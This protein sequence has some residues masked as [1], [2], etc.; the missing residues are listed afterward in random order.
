[1]DKKMAAKV[2]NKNLSFI[3]VTIFA[4]L[5]CIMALDRAIIPLKNGGMLN[6]VEYTLFYVKID[7]SAKT[8]RDV[9]TIGNYPLIPIVGGIIYNSYISIKNRK[10]KEE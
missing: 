8:Y 4:I 5:T 10:H 7:V 9:Y 6:N 1:M 3:I 2:A